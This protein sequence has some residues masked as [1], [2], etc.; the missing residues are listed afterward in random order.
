MQ[1]DDIFDL[2]AEDSEIN[3]TKISEEAIKIPKLHNKYY[4]IFSQERLLLRKLET[5]YKKLQ[6]QKY[7]YFMG[8][9]DRET[10]AENGWEP[11][12]RSILKS[13]IPMHL[14]AD[15]DVINLTLKLAYQKEKIT[16]L[17]SII[18]NVT[19]RGFMIKNYIEWQ[20]FSNGSS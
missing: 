7:E 19:E 16:L 1:L 5:E 9:L 18:K 20:K 8:T 4:K 17:E 6:L 11:N 2:W 12:P 3:T 14:E 13:D 10:L 15:K